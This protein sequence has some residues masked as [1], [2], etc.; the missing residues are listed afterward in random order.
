MPKP[1]VSIA[2]GTSSLK[3][4]EITIPGLQNAKLAYLNEGQKSYSR[5]APTPN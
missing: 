2:K 3:G 1:T 5:I 4:I